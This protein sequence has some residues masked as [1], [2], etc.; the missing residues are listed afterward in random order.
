MRAAEGDRQGTGA[1]P[2]VN[3]R[4]R[5][6]GGRSKAPHPSSSGRLGA[7]RGQPG[8][9]AAAGPEPAAAPTDCGRAQS[10]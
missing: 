2:A 8:V 3:S 5:E 7:D 6:K 9:T 4:E 10:G 1:V